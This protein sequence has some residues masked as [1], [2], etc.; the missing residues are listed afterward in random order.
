[1]EF[2]PLES[3]KT[4]NKYLR[5][6]SDIEELKKSIETVG[7]INPL[8]LNQE[9]KLIAGGRRY[10][11][12][13]ALG[14]TEAP[15][16]RIEKSELEQELVSIDENLV[17][18]DLNKMELEASLSRGRELYEKLY[19][20]AK[21][22]EAEDLSNPEDQ[23]INKELPND[24]RSF[25]D[26]TAEKTGLSKKVIKSA[27]E[28]EERASDKVKS[29]RSH[30]ELNA[31]QTNEIVKLEKED[32]EKIADLL[33][34]KSAK[35]IREI[36]KNVRSNGVERTIDQ[37]TNE[38]TLPNEY[39]SLQT[40]LTRTN[41]TLGK[42]LFEDIRIPSEVGTDKVKILDSIST[43]R[44]SL[45]QLLDLFSAPEKMDVEDGGEDQEENLAYSPVNMDNES[46]EIQPEI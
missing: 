19:P 44:I 23:E 30:G 12:L 20:S 33:P 3:I 1:M 24:Q 37:V 41:K 45:D 27:I 15:F 40:L 34:G 7:L 43:L 32:Q 5:L 29:L 4:N 28:R 26:L 13:K 31:S 17:R 14:K 25:I 16:V 8:I 21:K 11:A 38:K 9:D 18:K 2:I 6:N 46:S 35:E 10:S 42:I 39:K 36:V 22:V